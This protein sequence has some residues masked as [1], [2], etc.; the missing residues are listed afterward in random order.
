MRLISKGIG[1]DKLTGTCP[2]CRCK[3]ESTRKELAELL[4]P[5]VDMYISS[6]GTSVRDHV[7]VLCPECRKADVKMI[8]TETLIRW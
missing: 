1:E 3:F 7:Y 8:V 2:R 6:N 4:G 5:T